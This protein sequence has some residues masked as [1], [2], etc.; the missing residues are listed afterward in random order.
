MRK[1]SVAVIFGGMSSEYTVSLRSAASI[2]ENLDEDKYEPVKIGITRDGRWFLYDGPT[3]LILS[4]EWCVPEHTV[5]AAIAP[6][7]GIRSL[8]ALDGSDMFIPIDVA[9]PAVHGKNCE[10]G[11][12]QGLLRLAGIPFVGCDVTAS[13]LCMDKEYTHIIMEHHGIK[14]APYICVRRGDLH[15]TGAIARRIADE[16]S[17]PVFVKPANS[18]SS[19]GGSKVKSEQEL[20]AA[21]KTAFAEDDKVIIEKLIVGQEIECA[22]F[23]NNE[24]IAPLVGEIAPPDGFYDFDAKYINDSAGL[25]IPARMPEEAMD[26]VKEA[27]KR[28]FELAGCRGLS[29]VDFFYS[30]D[31]EVIFNEIN[32]LPGFTSISMY[33][34]LMVESGVSYQELISGLIDLALEASV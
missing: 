21:F 28:V 8:V 5:H 33:P 22:V 18:G 17:Y 30:A 4:D 12:L 14:M 1:L 7:K 25:Y 9:F 13:A 6:D 16:L 34:K 23:G 32:T 19:V 10:D 20:E 2:L 3:E 11:A 27:A 15:D 31:G 24:T 29:R 26:K